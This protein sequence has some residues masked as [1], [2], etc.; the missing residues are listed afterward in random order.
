MIGEDWECVSDVCQS[1][2]G[3]GDC[4]VCGAPKVTSTRD[5][6]VEVLTVMQ[7]VWFCIVAVAFVV[8]FGLCV[9]KGGCCG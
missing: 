4:S 2:G 9:W 5:E 3:Y 6:Q 1:C 8:V 7:K